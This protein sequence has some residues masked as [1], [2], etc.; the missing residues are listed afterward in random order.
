MS[1]L[2]ESL[3]Y[4]LMTPVLLLLTLLAILLVGSP[5][6]MLANF[7]YEKWLI[8]SFEK[9]FGA[10]RNILFIYNN[11]YKWNEYLKY[12]L[13][14]KIESHTV[15]L[16]I[17]D[18]YQNKKDDLRVRI[19]EHFRSKEEYCPLAIVINEQKKFELF[20]FYRPLLKNYRGNNAKLLR[21]EQKLLR[22][23]GFL[24]NQVNSV[25]NQ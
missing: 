20:H 10:D 8:R 13:F 15:L 11:N 5:F 1:L 4:I 23:S 17:T 22:A 2:F 16:D 24:D 18:G 25:V 12:E 9:R 7:W 6:I 14:P 19:F 3:L 21:L